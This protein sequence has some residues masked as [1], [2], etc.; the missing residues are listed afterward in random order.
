MEVIVPEVIDNFDA[1]DD[2]EIDNISEG[3]IKSL[4]P[5]KKDIHSSVEVESII[6]KKY[7]F[8]YKFS[9]GMLT[10]YGNFEDVPYEI[11]EINSTEGKRFFLNYKDNFYN[12][13]QTTDIMQLERVT[14]EALLSELAIVKENK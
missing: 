2:M 4:N 5:V 7:N 11:L 10:L 13:I 9:G 6:H 1:E 14:N 8:H 12:I 3:D